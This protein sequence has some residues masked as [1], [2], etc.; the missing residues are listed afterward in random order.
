M[1]NNNLRFNGL[2]TD[3]AFLF[4]ILSPTPQYK[5]MPPRAPLGSTKSPISGSVVFCIYF[6]AA[7]LFCGAGLWYNGGNKYIRLLG[8]DDSTAHCIS[9]W[10]NVIEVHIIIIYFPSQELLWPSLHCT[11]VP[12]TTFASESMTGRVPHCTV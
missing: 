4:I 12:R 9:H 8:M 10:A 3:E 5:L 11:Q 2:L 6:L 7:S 1:G